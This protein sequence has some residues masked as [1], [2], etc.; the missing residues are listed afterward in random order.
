MNRVTFLIA[1]TLLTV[2]LS[3]CT[4]TTEKIVLAIQPTDNPSRIE[5]QSK[6]LERFLEERTGYDVEVYL[7]LSYSG[8]VEALKYRHADAAMMSAWPSYVASQ[9]SD[10]R[11]VLAERREVVIDTETRVEPYYYSYFIVKADSP[12]QNLTAAAGTR[13]CFPSSTSTSG[14]VYPVAHLVEEGYLQKPA[15]GSADPR[16]YF[17]EVV[18]AGGYGQ[19]WEALKRDQV[20]VAVIAGDVS[21]TLYFDVL[22]QTR[23]LSQHG[24]IPSHAVVFGSRLQGEKADKLQAAM[25]DLKGEHRDVMRQLVSGIF[26]EFAPT[27]TQEH[28]GA[29][30]TALTTTGLRFQETL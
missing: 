17:G 30:Q 26:V 15:T 9:R 21:R 6:D 10:A 22:N 3:G 29:L 14:Y 28:L 11:V 19:C 16:S 24:P 27:T 7:P 20:D 8:T 13:A 1:A 18:F 23:Q 5:A 2:T 25:A 12:I 4:A